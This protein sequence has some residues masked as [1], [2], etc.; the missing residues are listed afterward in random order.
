VELAP[1]LE[2]VP[3]IGAEAHKAPHAQLNPALAGH[4]VVTAEEL[5]FTLNYDLNYRLG[6]DIAAQE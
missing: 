5:D 4:C 3:T 1:G 6:H 2:F